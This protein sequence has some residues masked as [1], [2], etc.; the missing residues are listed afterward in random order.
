MRNLL[1]RR[2]FGAGLFLGLTGIIVLTVLHALSR[3][4]LLDDKF[5]QVRPGM[6]RQEIFAILKPTDAVVA[7]DVVTWTG[8]GARLRVFFKD[9]RAV[10]TPIER[11]PRTKFQKFRDLVGL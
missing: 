6:T 7:G 3:R 4:P 1:K 10:M 11:L 8:S 2:S 9:D 5:V